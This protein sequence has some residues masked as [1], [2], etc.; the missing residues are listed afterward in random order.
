MVARIDPWKGQE[1]LVRAFAKASP[2]GEERLVLFGGAAFG[3]DEF[4]VELERLAEEL[5]VADRL[6]LAGHVSDVP[7]AIDSLD[8]CVQC[9]LRPEPLGQNVLQYLAAGKPTVVA[10]EG[11]PA[12]W[13]EDGVNGLTFT[14][15]DVDSLAAAL[16]RLIT[17]RA[18]RV[19][20]ARLAT[21]TPELLTDHEV[22]NRIA[23][24]LSEALE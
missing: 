1:L 11:G 3:H 23:A 16:D 4:P 21:L 8:I 2:A 9:S 24:F 18:L 12:E 22:G 20:L 19:R 13:V 5:G 10:A 14:P 15:R 6:Q 17:Q 7:G